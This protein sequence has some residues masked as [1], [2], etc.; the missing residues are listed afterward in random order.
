[1]DNREFKF[2]FDVHVD[3]IHV[4]GRADLGVVYEIVWSEVHV[5]VFALEGLCVF[6]DFGVHGKWFKINS[7]C[8]LVMVILEFS[9]AKPRSVDPEDF[10]VGS[11]FIW[12][13]LVAL[14]SY[15]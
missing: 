1:L 6:E 12:F 13:A 5:T 11:V 15:L 2:G 14:C 4:V 8:N 10:V 3:A 7:K 9:I